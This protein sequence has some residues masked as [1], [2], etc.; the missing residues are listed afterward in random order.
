[1]RLRLGV[2]LLALAPLPLAVT[3][4][5]QAI[6][7]NAA[8]PGYL[9]IIVT[10]TERHPEQQFAEPKFRV[11][12]LRLNQEDTTLSPRVDCTREFA[13]TQF[14][15]VTCSPVAEPALLDAQTTQGDRVTIEGRQC[16]N[17]GVRASI[18]GPVA[19][20]QV[21]GTIMCGDPVQVTASC[22]AVAA[23]PGVNGGYS[24]SC[25]QVAPEG[26]FPIRCWVDLSRVHYDHWEVTCYGTDP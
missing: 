20:E 11:E 24:G 3:A 2:A 10:A 8:R 25:A 14:F 23:L 15:S 13:P 6:E 22:T 4:P 7:V 19:L 16:V 5:A 18:S 1:M 9:N 21:T 26:P 12:D 17:A